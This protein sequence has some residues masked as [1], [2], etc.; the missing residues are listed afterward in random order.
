[1]ANPHRNIQ[2]TPL[3]KAPFKTTP[4]TF[5]GDCSGPSAT[6]GPYPR[7][8]SFTT[9]PKD[10]PESTSFASPRCSEKG[11]VFP[12]ASPRSA[13]CAYHERQMEEPVLFSS[14]Q[15][16]RLLLDP[17]RGLPA[18]ENY[19]EG[20]KRDRRRLARQWEEFLRDNNP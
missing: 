11:C 6:L 14:L 17:A 5:S 15:P 4:L 19:D 8:L 13:K 10:R 3:S 20:R 16:S 1:M 18:D 12:A 2:V 7:T 9:G